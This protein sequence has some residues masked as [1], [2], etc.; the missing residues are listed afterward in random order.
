MGHQIIRQ[1]DGLYAVFSSGTD[2][3]V[4]V[5]LTRER[6]IERRAEEAEREARAEAARLLD[7]VDAGLAYNWY[8]FD[9]ANE[10]SVKHGGEDLSRKPAARD[11]EVTPP[12]EEARR[13]TLYGP[14][15]HC[16]TARDARPA[17]RGSGLSYEFYCP[18]CGET[19]R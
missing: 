5:D 17:R 12:G 2:R 7:D 4:A 14:C 19:A 15:E 18:G 16:G 1:P 3:W 13:M 10:A 11:G 8:T 9:E 6:Y